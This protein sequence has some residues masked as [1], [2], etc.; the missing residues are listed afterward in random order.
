MASFVDELNIGPN[1]HFMDLG[2]GVGQLVSF[3]AAYAQT[4][5][6]VGVEIMPNL[7]QMARANEQFS[8]S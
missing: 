2:S 6:S 1:D 4:K 8:K 7:A 5:K 3:V